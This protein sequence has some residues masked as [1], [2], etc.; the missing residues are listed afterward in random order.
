MR[1]KWILEM[2]KGDFAGIAKE[3]GVS[4]LLVRCM[5]NRGLADKEQMRKYLEGTL[6]DL[7]NPFQMKDMEQA[8][9]LLCEAREKGKRIAIA[10]DFDCDG[11]FSGYIL[12]KCFEGE[13]F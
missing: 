11:I 1:E 5:L 10:S 7:H 9:E 6:A 12:W 2:K 8:V 3:L 13:S 4:P